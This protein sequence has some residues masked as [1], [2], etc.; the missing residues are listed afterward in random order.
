MKKM[1]RIFAVVLPMLLCILPSAPS[2]A[3]EGK[4]TGSITGGGAIMDVDVKDGSTKDESYKFGEYTGITQDGYGIGDFDLS[5]EGKDNFYADFLGKDLGWDSRSLSFATG[6]HGG[7]ELFLDYDQIPHYVSNDSKTIF[8]G[9]G[10]ND[11]TL[12]T[13]FERGDANATSGANAYN[14]T[15]FINSLATNARDIN[16]KTERKG[17]SIAVSAPFYDVFDFNLS[18]KKEDKDGLKYV[19]GVFGTSGG[20]RRSIALPEPVDYSTDEVN[21]SLGY[22]GEN[23]QLTLSYY[24]SNFDNKYSNLMFANPFQNL[25]VTSGTLNAV[26][27][28]GSTGQMALDPDNEH[29]RVGL[30]GAVDGQGL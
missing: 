17:G 22:L 19:G 15:N 30:A 12:P 23:V 10:T 14:R 24:F 18:Y 5:Y 13:G 1:K 26:S 27:Y 11:L 9:V 25:N 21:L 29:H 4:L 28:Y 20:D 3:E 2:L 6:W 16:I 8:E 7:Y